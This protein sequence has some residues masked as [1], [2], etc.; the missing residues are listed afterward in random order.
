MRHERNDHHP[1]RIRYHGEATDLYHP[2]ADGTGY[3]RALIR[4]DNGCEHAR[5]LEVTATPD[6]VSY[7]VVAERPDC[8]LDAF[9]IS[10]DLSTVALL[11]NL[12]G[13]SEL[14]ILEYSDNTLS[15]GYAQSD[16]TGADVYQ[17]SYME[18]CGRPP[19]PWQ[20]P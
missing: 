14:Q 13:R 11:W 10:D 18:T 6:G 20:L 16:F 15:E 19:M 17:E 7:Y 3:V 4:S 5:L 12:Q 8:D 9:A 2:G 1:R